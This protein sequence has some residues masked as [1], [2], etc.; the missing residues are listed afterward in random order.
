M[1]IRSSLSGIVLVALS[2]IF[3]ASC[4]SS[5]K[6]P[7]SSTTTQAA[8]RGGTLSYRMTA[9]PSSFNYVMT[10]SEGTMLVAFSLLMSPLT[11]FDHRTQKY[12]PGL[13]ESWKV[14]EDGLAVTVKLR[15]GAKFSDGK[16]ISSEDVV[17]TFKSIYD[18]KAN[19]PVWK[20]SMLVADK[21]IEAKAIDP[22]TVE[23]TFP[24]RVAAVEN[25]LVNLGVLPA[26]VLKGELDSGKFS[27]AWKLDSDPSKIVSSGPFTVESVAGGERIVLKRNPNYWKKDAK[28]EQLPYLDKLSLEITADSNNAMARLSQN[29]LDLVDRIRPA[30]FATLSGQPGDI[31][32]TDVG[33]GLGTDHIWFNLNPAK[34]NGEKLDGTTK[35]KW[36]SDVRFRRAISTAIDR[37]TIATTTLRGLASPLYNFVSPG[38]KTWA[39]AD[40]PKI[41]Y[42]REKAAQMLAEAGFVTKGTPE[43]PELFDTA[44]NRV[45]FTLVVP[46]ENEPRKLTAAVIQEDLAKL[47][48]KMEVAPV[49]TQNL[50]GRWSK[51]F[52]YDAILFG[53]SVSDTEPSSFGNFLNSNAAAHQWH[54]EQKTPATDW[55]ARID[56]LFAEQSAESDPQKRAALFGEIQQI[57]AEQLP[58]I[59]VV[60]RHIVTAAHIKIGNHSPSPIFPYSLWNADQ[61][62]I[63]Q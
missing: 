24:K 39:K 57:M 45:A 29:T 44:N 37:N 8:T 30:D 48:I 23:L 12:V 63:K 46:I 34:A 21:P 33:P 27:E 17:F 58:V 13:A 11:E 60:A 51:T 40:L 28:G 14:S 50:S 2:V 32:P 1:K 19:A 15:Q 38:N 41:E 22:L 49:E 16:D 18:E 52:D 5:S 43:A 62:F 25:Y 36:F 59:P 55:E 3:T 53:L 9:P 10:D 6:Q 20:D 26:H 56:K 42:S 7:I 47:G 61:L 35:Y 31:K 54:P 4:G